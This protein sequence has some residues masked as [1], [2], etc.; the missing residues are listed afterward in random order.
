M[1]LELCPCTEAVAE[2]ERRL[3]SSSGKA[4]H[5][6]ARAVQEWE[7]SGRVNY[8]LL[9]ALTI[10]LGNLHSSLL[11]VTGPSLETPGATYDEVREH[12]IQIAV[13][14]IIFYTQGDPA[15]GYEPQE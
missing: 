6:L 4:I 13:R 7:D 2:A 5:R 14:A 15:Y 11:R 1:A 12:L 10:E 8:H 3:D 9:A